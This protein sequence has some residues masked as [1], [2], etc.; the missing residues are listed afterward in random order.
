MALGV[1]HGWEVSCALRGRIQ[2]QGCNEEKTEPVGSSHNKFFIVFF[3]LA[4][5]WQSR[6]QRG[7]VIFSRSGCIY[8]SS[9]QNT[10]DTHPLGQEN[11]IKMKQQQQKNEIILWVLWTMCI[12]IALKKKTNKDKAKLSAVTTMRYL[13]SVIKVSVQA[14]GKKYR[15]ELQWICS[16]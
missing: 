14:S 8:Q 11:K 10:S 9:F 15:E 16:G 7:A 4:Y 13:F 12:G 2:K 3:P 1:T 5:L 6:A